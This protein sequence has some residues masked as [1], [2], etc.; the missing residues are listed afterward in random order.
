MGVIGSGSPGW[1]GVYVRP[2][3]GSLQG[4][5]IIV[6]Q[7][8]EDGGHCDYYIG[9]G[10]YRPYFV[11][12][13][14]PGSE[15]AGFSQMGGGP[16]YPTAGR[17]YWTMTGAKVVVS[18]NSNQKSHGGCKIMGLPIAQ[19]LGEIIRGIGMPTIAGAYAGSFATPAG[20]TVGMVTGALYGLYDQSDNLVQAF[21]D[22]LDTTTGTIPAQNGDVN[23]TPG[24]ACYIDVGDDPGNSSSFISDDTGGGNKGKSAQE[25]LDLK[26][27]I[28]APNNTLG[29]LSDNGLPG[30]LA[31]A[32]DTFIRG[33]FL[34]YDPSTIASGF[35]DAL[36]ESGTGALATAIK[37][38]LNLALDSLIKKGENDDVNAL[39]EQQNGLLAKLPSKEDYASYFSYKQDNKVISIPEMMQNCLS[40]GTGTSKINLIDALVIP[41]VAPETKN[42]TITKAICDLASV[43][44]SQENIIIEESY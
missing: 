4:K 34:P 27:A 10:S 16:S 36:Q 41:P 23:V 42:Y 19:R 8:K 26:A 32:L 40:V 14:N 24:V 20:S 29:S 44:S 7:P 28:N 39:I 6:S 38:L 17:C 43:A 25:S 31:T 3:G 33:G 15:V 11:D 13:D 22:I 30:R 37:S 5:D 2:S 21:R 1:F 12:P 35:S 9:S 18:P